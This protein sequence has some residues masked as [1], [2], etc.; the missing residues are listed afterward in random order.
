MS[1]SALG[2]PLG[3]IGK[4][5]Q[6]VVARGLPGR[7]RRSPR[8]A[9]GERY[10]T[11]VEQAVGGVLLTEADGTIRY[12][13]PATEEILGYSTDELTGRNAFDLIHPEDV[14]RILTAVKEIAAHGNGTAYEYLRA[15]HSGGDWLW[16]AVSLRNLLD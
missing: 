8:M 14:G 4:A 11:L 2:S 10:R 16:L 3:R 5:V 9:S 6:A 7:D 1:F 13:G 12:A 15:S